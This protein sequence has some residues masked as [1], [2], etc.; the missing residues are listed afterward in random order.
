MYER[1]EQAEKNAF[2]ESCI[3]IYFARRPEL[4]PIVNKMSE[5]FLAT[6]NER[7]E[8]IIAVLN[9]GTNF[10][11]LKDELY[12]IAN[13]EKNFFKGPLGALPPSKEIDKITP[14]E[15]LEDI[16]KM[17]KNDQANLIS[18]MPIHSVFYYRIFRL[19]ESNAYEKAAS[20]Y[21]T[22][23]ESIE[24]VKNPELKDPKDPIEKATKTYVERKAEDK[25]VPVTR[26]LGVAL[27]EEHCKTINEMDETKELC[28]SIP[29]LEHRTSHGRFQINIS[30]EHPDVMQEFQKHHAPLA[31]GPSSHA[32]TLLTG[33]NTYLLIDPKMSLTTSESL[34]YVW[35]YAS[36]LTTAFYHTTQEVIYT[37]T[38][39]LNLKYS[40]DSY[41]DNLPENIQK[42]PEFNAMLEKI[43]PKT[44]AS[45]KQTHVNAD[46][47]VE[48]SVSVAGF[49]I[50]KD[51]NTAN[52]GTN[53]STT[54]IQE[55][56]R[57]EHC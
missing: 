10:K 1:T 3:T 23:K 12:V 40:M 6:I 54:P 14:N 48:T 38:R 15:A 24:K 34:S 44:N 56:P 32:I 22:L 51:K 53:I 2:L 41:I 52:T 25:D 17:L 29:V 7:R 27:S 36:Y 21:K 18:I 45:E 28:K 37:A 43:M 26:Q 46:S 49:S 33:A 20:N 30:Q 11:S 5:K 4:F 8:E 39:C 57:M 13:Y 19:L 42:N 9:K 35:A 47:F 55:V 31:A 50:L 16:E